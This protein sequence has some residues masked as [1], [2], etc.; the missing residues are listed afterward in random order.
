MP[1]RTSAEPN[2]KYDWSVSLAG[3]LE[4]EGMVTIDGKALVEKK[5]ASTCLHVHVE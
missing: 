3:V 4:I 5:G 1:A 2:A